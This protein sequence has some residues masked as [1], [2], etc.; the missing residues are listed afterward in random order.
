[1]TQRRI[2]G[3]QSGWVLSRASWQ[4]KVSLWSRSVGRQMAW[5]WGK[6]ALQGRR[7]FSHS[8]SPGLVLALRQGCGKPPDALVHTLRREYSFAPAGET[9]SLTPPPPSHVSH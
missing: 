1:M 7:P 6:K 2:T 5:C 9:W 8:G 4:H 3:L